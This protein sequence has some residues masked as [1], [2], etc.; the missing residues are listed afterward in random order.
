MRDLVPMIEPNVGV[1]VEC[2]GGGLMSRM[3]RAASS[4]TRM[5]AITVIIVGLA[6]NVFLIYQRLFLT[7][8]V[9]HG[10]SMA[11][12]INNGDAV[13]LKDV[14][15]KDIVV[16]QVIV[17]RDWEARDDFIVHRV[18]RIEDDGYTR[19]FT[20]K[21]DNSPEVDPVKTPSGGVAGAVLV[22]VPA[23]GPLLQYL[24]TTRG[25]AFAVMVPILGG[26]LL[27]TM[28]AVVERK[29]R[30]RCVT[31]AGAYPTASG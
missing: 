7:I 2:P 28:Q 5:I 21:G 12:A 8:H 20:T 14:D 11:P 23:F 4:A 6:L 25:F 9:V 15:T 31:A 1:P 27:V 24:S 18:V 10:S 3:R 30:N 16:G 22:H 26:L 17:F 19:L 13:L 29:R